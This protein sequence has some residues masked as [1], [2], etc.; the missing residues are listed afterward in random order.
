LQYC[1]IYVYGVGR[2]I[3]IRRGIENVPPPYE[4][5]YGDPGVY[6]IDSLQAVTLVDELVALGIVTI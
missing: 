1:G 2:E 5:A 4:S 6:G 3:L